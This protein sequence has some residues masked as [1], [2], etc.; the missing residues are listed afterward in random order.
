MTI[1][2]RNT[3]RDLTRDGFRVV[4]I[5]KDIV[6]LTKGADARIVMLDG[7]QKRAHHQEYAK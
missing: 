5:G 2:Q 3:V 6:R 4:V 1:P 7:S